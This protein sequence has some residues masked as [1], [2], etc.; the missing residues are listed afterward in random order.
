MNVPCSKSE[1]LGAGL[2]AA[3]FPPRGVGWAG[4]GF[5]IKAGVSAPEAGV[6]R[7]WGEHCPQLSLSQPG[8]PHSPP[9]PPRGCTPLPCPGG[10][11]EVSWPALP[12][13]SEAMRKQ[14]PSLAKR[15]SRGTRW[16]SNFHSSPQAWSWPRWGS[17]QPSG[18]SHRRCHHGESSRDSAL[19]NKVAPQ[20]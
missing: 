15:V 4:R 2:Q 17:G 16:P 18:S 11:L 9:L 12:S 8:L 7:P 13:S 6:S 20:P 5:P 3:N 19:P 14:T 10:C 1:N